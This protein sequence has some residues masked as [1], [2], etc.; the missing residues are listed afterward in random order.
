MKQVESQ[1]RKQELVLKAVRGRDKKKVDEM[2]SWSEDFFVA[3]NMT[4]FALVSKEW[5]VSL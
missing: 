5:N 4:S 2:K 1:L 3:S